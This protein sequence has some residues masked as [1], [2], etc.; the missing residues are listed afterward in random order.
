MPPQH[1]L[2]LPSVAAGTTTTIT[3][4][5]KNST[6][7]DDVVLVDLKGC[8]EHVLMSALRSIKEEADFAVKG[9]GEVVFVAPTSVVDQTLCRRG[10][11]L[12]LL[13]NFFP[14]LSMESP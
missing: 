2:V 4:T 12:R 9:G 14:H 5:T 6:R 1:L 13:K 10:V 3:T 11:R 7:C 8:S